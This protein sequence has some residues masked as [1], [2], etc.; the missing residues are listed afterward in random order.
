M[1]QIPVIARGGPA[2]SVPRY[3]KLFVARR[4]ADGKKDILIRAYE[5][6]DCNRS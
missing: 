4:P 1:K 6:F 2:A 5:A 3:G